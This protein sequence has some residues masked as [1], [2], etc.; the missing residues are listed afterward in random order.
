[1]LFICSVSTFQPVE[2][3]SWNLVWTL[4]W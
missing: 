3:H 2:Q 4:W 1:M